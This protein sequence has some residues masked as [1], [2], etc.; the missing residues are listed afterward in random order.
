MNDNLDPRLQFIFGRRS[1]RRFAPGEVGDAAIA[2][3]LQAAMAAPSAAATDPWR[4]VVVRRRETLNKLAAALPYGGMLAQASAGFVVCGDL[5]AAHDRQLSYLLQ[6]CSAAIENLLLCAHAL[7]L[8]GCWLGVHPREDRV[9]KLK[10]IFALPP[11]VIPVS[12]V[13]I[14]LPAESKEART[15][16]NPAYVHQETW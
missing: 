15:R 13:A 12:A 14:G 8:G 16:F 5:E 3:L 7:G 1:I 2:K 11:S 6:D 10:A 4:F 9:A